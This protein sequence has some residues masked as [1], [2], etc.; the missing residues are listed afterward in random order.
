MEFVVALLTLSS[1][2]LTATI[3]M[4]RWML[5]S[6]NYQTSQQTSTAQLQSEVLIHISNL[7]ASKDPLA[8][9]QV[10]AVTNYVE[11]PF[12][13]LIQTGDELELARLEAEAKL[14]DAA[15]DARLSDME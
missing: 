1:L 15:F 6:L 5:R 7:L 4:V 11:E 9:Q 12:T 3:L 14:M 8:F 2:F 10:N 13:G